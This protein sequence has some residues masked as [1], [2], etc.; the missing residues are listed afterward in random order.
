MKTKNI[1][2]DSLK[3]PETRVTSYFDSEVYTEFKR[4]IATSGILTP[5]IVI[6]TPEG[7]FLVDGL[8][9]LIEARSAGDKTI[10]AVI[11]PG[12]EVD[13]VL[14]NLMLTTL[15]GKARIQEVRQ[16]VDMLTKEHSLTPDGIAE[17][18]GMSQRFVEDLLI[19]SMMPPEVVEAFDSGS[20]EKGKALALYKIPDE[21]GRSYIFNALHGK[22]LTVRDWQEYIDYYLANRNAQVVDS[23]PPPPPPPP[24]GKCDICGSDQELRWLQL[25]HM[26]PECL[27]GTKA[28]Y[29]QAIKELPRE[30]DIAHKPVGG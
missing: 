16:V 12:E 20:L 1:P 3:I 25:I 10:A 8:H 19:I 24:Q 11:M 7:Y 23:A 27:G 21:R 18:T 29:A 26:C 2:I 22:R 13:V 4:T 17:R 6:E 5:V 9:R 28:A 15:H 14:K 30:T